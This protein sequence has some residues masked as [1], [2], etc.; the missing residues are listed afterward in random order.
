M[1]MDNTHLSNVYR[2][3]IACLNEQDWSALGNFVHDDVSHNS[4]PFGLSGYRKMLEKDFDD[5]PDLHFTI[6]LLVSDP[7]CIASRLAFSCTPKGRFLGLSVNGKKISFTENVFYEFREEKIARVWS[8]LDKTAIE[9]Q[10]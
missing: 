7:P 10:L 1:T 9:A 3:Y 6:Q 8:V 5:I 4:Q 2:N